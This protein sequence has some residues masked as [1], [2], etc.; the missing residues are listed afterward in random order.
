MPDD[1]ARPTG[2][3]LW[4]GCQRT[5]SLSVRTVSTYRTG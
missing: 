5:P 1:K 2:P 4:R 3:D